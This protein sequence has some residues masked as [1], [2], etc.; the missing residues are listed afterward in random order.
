MNPR[1]L[2]SNTSIPDLKVIRR[3]AVSDKR[4]YLTRI[5]CI[6][7]L[8][9]LIQDRNI[10]QINHT[11]TA[12]RGTVR[13][14]HFQYPPHAEI[15][16]VTCIKGEVFDVAVDVRNS[17]PSY[18]EHHSEILSAKNQKILL[19]PEGFAH[20]F[21]ALTDDCELLY[22]HT[23]T[24]HSNSEGALNVR[25]PFLSISWPLI[26]TEISDRDSLHP[27]IEEG[28]LGMKL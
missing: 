2:V 16:M 11:Y 28:F 10:E 21:Q 7:E 14:F 8:Q 4:G 26:I 3:I 15:K 25:D 20:G 17:K 9:T 24:Y 13:G 6:E 1:F 23:S 5:F 19:I 12:K 22:L 18:L 27:M